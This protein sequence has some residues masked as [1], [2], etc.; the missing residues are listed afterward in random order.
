ML[1]LPSLAFKTH[2]DILEMASIWLDMTGEYPDPRQ[3][4]SL[5]VEF[6]YEFW[7][8]REAEQH[9]MDRKKVPAGMK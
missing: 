7:R 3:I 5:D 8:W 4:A 1:K 6:F 2:E 9:Y